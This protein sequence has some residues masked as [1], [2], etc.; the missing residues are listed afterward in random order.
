ML[1]LN[2]LK[3]FVKSWGSGVV[4]SIVHLPQNLERDEPLGRR[5]RK[6][7]RDIIGLL[8]EVVRG[9]RR[10]INVLEIE[11]FLIAHHK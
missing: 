7:E 1:L 8:A 10:S 9:K 3:N 6:P 5:A 4:V 11:W 2:N